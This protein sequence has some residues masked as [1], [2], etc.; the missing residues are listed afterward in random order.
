MIEHQRTKYEKEKEYLEKRPM[1]YNDTRRTAGKAR[2]K[3]T[4]TY[5]IP[6]EPT[7]M[8]CDCPAC[9]RLKSEGV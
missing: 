8:H 1:F 4:E 7:D 9:V 5:I 3:R 6:D 2:R